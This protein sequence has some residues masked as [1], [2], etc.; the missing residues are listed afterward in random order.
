MFAARTTRKVESGGGSLRCRGLAAA[1]G[2]HR[3]LRSARRMRYKLH[4]EIEAE[5]PF[6]PAQLDAGPPVV[7]YDEVEV[8]DVTDR[9]SGNRYDLLL[10]RCGGNAQFR[11]RR[12][13][14]PQ[15]PP[16]GQPRPAAGRDPVLRATPLPPDRADPAAASSRRSAT[17]PRS[18]SPASRPGITRV[19]GQEQETTLGGRDVLLYPLYHPAAALYTPAMLRCWSRTSRGCPSCSA[20]EAA[21]EPGCRAVEAL[22]APSRPS[23]SASSSL[24]P[25]AAASVTRVDRVASPEE[26]EASRR[27]SP[28]SCGPATSSPSPASSAPAR[29]PS[30]AAPAAR[31]A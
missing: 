11:N 13:R 19:H 14:R 30:C 21:P 17:S 15:M 16:S 22:V 3:A 8:E 28:R 12:R 31:S 5:I 7:M 25:A 4:P 2:T 20:R 6:D 10:H 1:F 29:R 18:S 24:A 23:S 27:S 26:T 9:T